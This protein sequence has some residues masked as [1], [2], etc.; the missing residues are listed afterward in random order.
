MDKRIPY[1]TICS[2]SMTTTTVTS[3]PF[4]LQD[5][6]LSACRLGGR[7]IGLPACTTCRVQTLNIADRPGVRTSHFRSADRSCND[8]GMPYSS[9]QIWSHWLVVQM[10]FLVNFSAISPSLLL[11]YIIF[12]QTQRWNPMIIGWDHMKKF[13]EFTLVQKDIAHL[14][15]MHLATIKTEYKIISLAHHTDTHTAAVFS[16]SCMLVLSCTAVIDCFCVL[17]SLYFFIVFLFV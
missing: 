14:Y 17:C 5:R 9:M 13:Q 7:P 15:S 6:T 1:N 3:S 4:N 11:A 10:I 12:Y 2:D 16:Y 8:R